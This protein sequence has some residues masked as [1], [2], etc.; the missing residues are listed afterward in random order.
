[1]VL[2]YTLDENHRPVPAVETDGKSGTLEK[3][4]AD[5]FRWAD[6]WEANRFIADDRL[7]TGHQVSTMFLGLDRNAG[8]ERPP[9][10]FE[11]MVFDAAKPIG[12]QA[13][14]EFARYYETYEQAMAGHAEI[15]KQ[16]RGGQA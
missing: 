4:K 7:P 14:W 2:Y 3:R 5:L 12:D 1:M 6:W 10:F 11:T 9:I 13:I 8:I 16:V 15:L